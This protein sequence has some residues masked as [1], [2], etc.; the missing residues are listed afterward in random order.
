MLST[1][2][3]PR[4]GPGALQPALGL[5][6]EEQSKRQVGL[7]FDGAGPQEGGAWRWM[8]LR[9][10]LGCRGKRDAHQSLAVA[11]GDGA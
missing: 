7:R 8:G 10:G 4:T 5:G 1:S 6:A 2:F 9:E 11:A 3:F